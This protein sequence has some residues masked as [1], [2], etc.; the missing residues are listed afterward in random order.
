[1]TTNSRWRNSSEARS[2][3]EWVVDYFSFYIFSHSFFIILAYVTSRHMSRAYSLWRRGLRVGRAVWSFPVLNMPPPEAP[4]EGWI[5]ELYGVSG[6]PGLDL[7]I[8]NGVY[9][10]GCVYMHSSSRRSLRRT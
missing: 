10:C 2:D 5:K 1:M 6:M 3:V 4:G 8:V 9:V 7:P